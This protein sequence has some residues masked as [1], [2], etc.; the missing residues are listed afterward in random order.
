[1]DLVELEER[2]RARGWSGRMLPVSWRT[3]RRR[4]RLRGR[5]RG[6]RVSA[7]RLV[8]PDPERL[9]RAGVLL[10][11]WPMSSADISALV[12]AMPALRWIH[13]ANTGVEDVIRAT[14]GRDEL[15]ITNAG[16]TASAVVAEHAFASV[17]ALAR[18]LPEHFVATVQREWATPPA[19]RLEGSTL[20]V[21]GFGRIGRE[22][23]R[24]AAHFGMRVIAVRRRP[25]M[26]TPDGVSEMIGPELLRERLGEADFVLLA[27]PATSET[28]DLVDAGFLAAMRPDAALV[29]VGRGECVV[30]EDLA[31][32]LRAG[33]PRAACLDVTRRQPLPRRSPLYGVPGLWLTHYSAYRRAPAEH[34]QD[35]RR[36]FLEN[37][38]EF[39]AGRELPDSVDR[40]RG[41]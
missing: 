22:V 6:E 27:L 23:A 41:Y 14:E 3:A 10:H 17:L 36:G 24:H 21:V 37:L 7:R 26:E 25:D 11:A 32:A 30:E 15:V 28:K 33:H 34:L 8:A 19:R 40:A 20:L 2:A 4:E 1:M 35:A 9:E 31:A 39:V 18:R 29:N 16:S 5:L 38:E 12:D 13:S